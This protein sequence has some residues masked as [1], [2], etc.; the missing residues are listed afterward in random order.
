MSI[1]NEL[2]DWVSNHYSGWPSKQ[3]EGFAI[4]DR[5]EAEYKRMQ[6]D[7]AKL[8]ELVGDMW[9]Y[10]TEPVSKRNNL[11]ERLARFDDIGDRMCELGIEVNE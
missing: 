4:A 2:R 7:N 3:A 11:K 10:I 6:D 1:T 9:T 8:R 5:I